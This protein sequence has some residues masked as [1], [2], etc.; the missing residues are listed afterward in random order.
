MLNRT[1]FENARPDGFPVLEVAPDGDDG[2]RRFVP[3]KRSELRG[4][5]AGPLAALCL[6][7]T[8]G[9]GREAFPGACLL[10]TSDAADEL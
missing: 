5:V 7:Q 1:A 10:Y 9:F 2:P 6:T 4:E 3:L 8:F